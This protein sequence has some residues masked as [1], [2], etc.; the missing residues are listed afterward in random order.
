[1]L[2]LL[3]HSADYSIIQWLTGNVFS[4]CSHLL[5]LSFL[6]G[7]HYHEYFFKLWVVTGLHAP[8][9]TQNASMPPFVKKT[10]P[11]TP[12]P[13]ETAPL[14][15][16]VTQIAVYAP[17]SHTDYPHAPMSHIPTVHPSSQIAPHSHLCYTDC[18]QLSLLS[19]TTPQSLPHTN[20]SLSMYA[21]LTDCSP[22]TKTVS[23]APTFN[24]LPV[25]LYW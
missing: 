16:S 8:Y 10:A 19:Q 13:S 25:L 11:H 23:Y 4:D 22:C 7:L 12:P 21:P 1:M 15:P 2:V 20:C 18:S 5:F 24:Y 17:I 3:R 9:I 6:Y 14:V